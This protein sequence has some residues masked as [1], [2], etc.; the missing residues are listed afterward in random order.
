MANTQTKLHKLQTRRQ[1]LM[2]ELQQVEKQIKHELHIQQRQVQ[3][4]S[5]YDFPAQTS[6]ANHAW[7]GTRE[8]VIDRTYPSQTRKG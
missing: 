7:D 6:D 3:Q 4:K 8:L 2:Q 1:Q 5:R